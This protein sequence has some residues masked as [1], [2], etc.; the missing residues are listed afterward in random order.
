MQE[1]QRLTIQLKL[2]GLVT[3]LCGNGMVCAHQATSKTF[4]Q[5]QSQ[6][7]MSD[8]SS[9]PDLDKPYKQFCGSETI[10]LDLEPT[11]RVISDPDP[12][13]AWGVI[14]DPDLCL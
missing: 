10:I 13:P 2:C 6:Q 4:K 3:E 7:L 12:D 5:K 14:S 11:W 8:G 9:S 1:F